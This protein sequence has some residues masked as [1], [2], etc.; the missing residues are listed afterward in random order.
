MIRLL[1]LL[2]L[3]QFCTIPE[4]FLGIAL[5]LR[6]IAYM[7]FNQSLIKKLLLLE[8]TSILTLTLFIL[9][10]NAGFLRVEFFFILITFFLMEAVVGLALTISWRRNSSLLKLNQVL[11]LCSL[12]K[13]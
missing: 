1:L 13:T 12:R 6:L 4:L 9:L 3:V 11:W 7:I 10:H 2:T 8:T 5:R